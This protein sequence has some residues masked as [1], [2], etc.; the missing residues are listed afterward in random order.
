MRFETEGGAKKRTIVLYT[1]DTMA[2]WEYTY[3][4]LISRARSSS[5]PDA[6][7]SYSW[8]TGWNRCEHSGTCR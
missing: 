8:A 6:F 7:D 1:T 5:S 2:G 4:T 3:L